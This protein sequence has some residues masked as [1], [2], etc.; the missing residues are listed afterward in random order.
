M[1]NN[2]SLEFKY[3]WSRYVFKDSIIVIFIIAV[4]KFS[5]YAPWWC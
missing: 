2:I 3:I 5:C 1:K 4:V